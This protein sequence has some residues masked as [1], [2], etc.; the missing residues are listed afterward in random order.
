MERGCTSRISLPREILKN[1]SQAEG[2]WFQ[3]EL[4]DVL[5]RKRLENMWINLNKQQS[6]KNVLKDL[7]S[8]KI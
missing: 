7:K 3:Y 4:Q 5:E 1:P 2:E 8:I 6:Y